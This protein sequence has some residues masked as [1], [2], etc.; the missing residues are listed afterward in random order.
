MIYTIEH[1]KE[2]KAAINAPFVSVNL[3]TLGGNHRASLMV[4][5]SVDA[6]ETWQN[7]ILE[8]SRYARFSVTSGEHKLELFSGGLR[9]VKFRKCNAESVPQIAEK[10]NGWIAKAKE[11]P[12]D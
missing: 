4:C 7:G 11:Q 8:N 3:S 10:I 5:V 1:A 9:S 6:R 12:N 2:L